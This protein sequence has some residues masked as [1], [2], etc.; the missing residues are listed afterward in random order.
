MDAQGLTRPQR[1]L[2]IV[3]GRRQGLPSPTDSPM[4][5]RE[6]KEEIILFTQCAI[7]ICKHVYNLFQIAL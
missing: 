1:I 4:P 2:I 3:D 7:R 6:K 5:S